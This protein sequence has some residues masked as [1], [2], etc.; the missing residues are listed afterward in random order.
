MPQG[1][2]GSLLRHIRRLIGGAEGADAP[3][4]LLLRQFVEHG[5][6]AAFTA[7][8]QRHGPLVMGLCR[9]V[10]PDAHEAEDAFQ[11]VF[12]ILAKRAAAIRRPEALASWLY[13]VAYRV[14]ARARA[15]YR[16]RAT[17]ESQVTAMPGTDPSPDERVSRE[18][19]PLSEANRRELRGVIDEELN[20]LPEKYRLPMILC[21]LE[22]KSNEEAAQQ[23]RW[24]KGT[25]SGQLARGRDLL[26]H[27]LARRG[28]A[29]SAGAVVAA[30]GASAGLAAVTPALV[31]TTVQGALLFNAGKAVGTGA[32]AAATLAQT[33]LHGMFLAK[34]KVAAAVLAGVMVLG[35]A[36][37][38]VAYQSW[39][40]HRH[41]GVA[42]ASTTDQPQPTEPQARNFDPTRSDQVAL[43]LRVKKQGDDRQAQGRR[44]QEVVILEVLKN[45]PG[46]AVGHTML[47]ASTNHKHG[48]PAEEC[49]IYL[50]PIRPGDGH[51]QL[52]GGG[53][54]EGISHP[55]AVRP[56]A[57]H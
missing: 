17:R 35:S 19:D 52:L 37:G 57:H 28:V 46:H 20:R 21:Y 25:V 8:V 14:A 16:K 3:D 53:A 43:V 6:E 12:M 41:A 55:A 22:G 7:L 10:L 47:V 1:Q 23:L 45:S 48:L 31:E 54:P 40:D 49:T 32:A 9:R 24:T 34:V 56:P 38:L 11:A 13:G 18:A 15:G 33:T 44:W 2:L 29:L 39:Q 27:R 42:V 4:A 36:G 51:W 30:L 5:D 26:R 50:E